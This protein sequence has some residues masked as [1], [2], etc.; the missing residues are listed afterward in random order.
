MAQDVIRF[1]RFALDLRK[2]QLTCSGEPVK[3]NSRALDLLCELADAGG[4]IVAKSQLMERVWPGRI[5]EE[6]AIEVHISTLRKAIEAGSE[7]QS[8]VVTVP[9]RGYRLVGIE[10]DSMSPSPSDADRARVPGTSVAVLRFAN[11]SGDPAQDYFAD[12]IVEDIITGLSRI[13]GV[14][15]I[16]RNSSIRFAGDLDPARVGRDLGCRYLVQGSA[17]KADSRVRINAR[18]VEAKTGVSIW[19]E[20]YDRRL[21]DLFEVQDA[22]AMS[23]IGAI[24]P[25]LRKAE[26]DRVRRKRPDN[27]DAYDLVLQALPYMH[28][29]MPAGADE[30]VPLLQKVLELEPEYAAAQAHLARCYHFRYSRRGLQAADRETSVRLA[31]AA[32]TSDDATVLAT[33][34][35]VI[36]FDDVDVETALALMERALTISSSNVVALGNSAFVL[37]WMGQTELAVSRARRALDLSPFDTAIAYLAIAI[38]LIHMGSIRDAYSAARRAAEAN[39]QSSIPHVLSAVALVGLGRKEE[40]KAAASRALALDP[41][42]TMPTWAMTVNKNPDVFEPMAAA[43]AK[44]AT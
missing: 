33:A 7:G 18:V 44:L 28:S 16:G 39:P 23:L 14:F 30:A 29:T 36:W 41:T 11:L 25:N 10:V 9:G 27:L 19:A 38:A 26:I 35:L 8:Y 3:L 4:G 17:R 22:I 42:F 31:R 32:M 37:A 20:R 6:N 13:S 2:R 1:G 12:G 5:V 24:E 21:D 43:W 40:A 34:G 15:V